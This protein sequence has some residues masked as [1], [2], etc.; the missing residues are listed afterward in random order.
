MGDAIR[1]LV[2]EGLPSS[3]LGPRSILRDANRLQADR[4]ERESSVG[5]ALILVE[6]C[7]ET[8]GRFIAFS[9]ELA[10]AG[11]GRWID[12]HLYE[13]K[14]IHGERGGTLA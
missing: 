12:F 13:E 8:S 1:S 3:A 4:R 2:D 6:I 5:R 10:R 11:S 14:R 7:R 9:T